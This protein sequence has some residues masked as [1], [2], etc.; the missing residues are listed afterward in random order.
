MTG[1]Q[2]QWSWLIA[3][4]LFLG[5]LGAGVFVAT[6]IIAL[7]SGDRFKSTV[8]FGAWAGATTIALGTLVLLIDVGKP[9]RAIIMFKS[10]VNFNSWMTR[11]AWLLFFAVLLNGLAALLW[12]DWSLGLFAR[13][14]NPLKTKRTVFRAILAAIGIPLNLG[15]AAYTGILLG[16]LPFRPL[17]HTWLLPALFVASA[18]DTGVG[19][20]TGYASLR[21]KAERA[22]YLRIVLEICILLLILIESVALWQFLKAAFNGA[23]DA[24]KSAQIVATGPLA[25]PFWILVVGCGL[26]IPFLA[27]LSQLSGVLR[28]RALPVSLVGTACCLAGGWT[29]RFLVLSAGL[30]QSLASPAWPQILAG[31]QLVIH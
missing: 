25:V 4:Y 26:L 12:T 19:L 23:P 9:F 21:E 20:V 8:R 14:W 15:V 6:S 3:I 16:V 31:V 11:G 30:P 5:G 7:I 27:C 1:L 24:A 29:L 10:F 2:T 17:W 22:N 18:M 28:R 13:I